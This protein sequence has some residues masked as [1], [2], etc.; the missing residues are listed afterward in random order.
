MFLLSFIRNALR[1]LVPFVFL[2]NLE[3][4]HVEVLCLVKLKAVFHIFKIAQSVLNRAK[5]HIL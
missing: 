2:K 4:T 5:H 3:N 1:S